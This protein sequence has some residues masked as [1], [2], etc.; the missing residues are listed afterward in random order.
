MG[1]M[2]TE[3]GAVAGRRRKSRP[4][5]PTLE[6]EIGEL[7]SELRGELAPITEGSEREEQGI[8]G[9]PSS[10]SSAAALHKKR[11]LRMHTAPHLAQT[12]QKFDDDGDAASVRTTN[13]YQP[14]DM[15]LSPQ[16]RLI[17]ARSQLG[18]QT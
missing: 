18:S 4:S 1:S 12:P 11:V 17:R 9:S 3:K 16:P 8:S 10:A 2:A 14:S 6:E 7:A 15:G 5:L 13:P